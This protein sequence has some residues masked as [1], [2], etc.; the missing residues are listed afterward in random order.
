[1]S[2]QGFFGCSK[3]G[4]FF[5]PVSQTKAVLPTFIWH[6]LAAFHLLSICSIPFPAVSYK[7][8]VYFST[9]KQEWPGLRLQNGSGKRAVLALL[10]AGKGLWVSKFSVR[11]WKHIFGCQ[12]CC[13]FK[14]FKT[15]DKHYHFVG[16]NPVILAFGGRNKQPFCKKRLGQVLNI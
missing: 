7:T 4:N 3:Q 1:M 11:P 13:G 6:P 9:Q 12:S 5:L 15:V 2:N 8:V 14:R 16:A 10:L